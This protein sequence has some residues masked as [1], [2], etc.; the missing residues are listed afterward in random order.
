MIVVLRTD[1]MEVA[2]EVDAE[3]DWSLV[4]VNGLDIGLDDAFEPVLV[5]GLMVMVD[6]DDDVDG[7]VDLV[8]ERRV[9]LDMVDEVLDDALMVE[10][11]LMLASPLIVVVIFLPDPMGV[12]VPSGPLPAGSG[13]LNS[14][15]LCHFPV[16][17][18]QL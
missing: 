1:G 4:V 12:I 2:F 10:R 5:A 7:I 9:S 15:I 16:R 11:L 3:L 14:L 17:S 18:V 6:V 8:V 13:S